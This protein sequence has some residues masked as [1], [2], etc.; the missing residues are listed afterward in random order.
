LISGGLDANALYA[1]IAL[2]RDGRGTFQY[3]NAI[4]GSTTTAATTLSIPYWV[5]VVRSGH[6][7]T[8]YRSTSGTP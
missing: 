6:T 3:R 7:F 2:R 1:T 8:A 5:K 4:G